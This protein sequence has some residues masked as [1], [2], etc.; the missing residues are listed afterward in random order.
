MY[1][2][3]LELHFA[4]LDHLRGDCAALQTCSLTCRIWLSHVQRSLYETIQVD[5]KNAGAFRWTMTRRPELACNIRELT[6]CNVNRIPR[7]PPGLRPT[8]IRLLRL[9]GMDMT[10][11]WITAVLSAS[12]HSVQQLSLRDFHAHDME[13]FLTFL[14]EM[15]NLKNI[16]IERGRLT[17][18]NGDVYPIGPS[19]L[20]SLSLVGGESYDS[21][22]LA[23]V[24]VF[25][26]DPGSYK[27][28]SILKI[29]LAIG[30][31][32]LFD[33]FLAVA[34]PNLRELDLGIQS[35]GTTPQ[36]FPL[37]LEYCSNLLLFALEFKLVPPFSG[38][39]HLYYVPLLLSTLAAP[40]L[41]RVKLVAKAL[42]ASRNDLGTLDWER[43]GQVLADERFAALRRVVVHVIGGYAIRESVMSFIYERLPVLQ[44]RGILGVAHEYG[45]DMKWLVR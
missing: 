10:N 34:G 40:N 8:A 44:S 38:M 3:P 4:I 11:P 31:L 26:A 18:D 32:F 6:F 14:R 25:L 35:N 9:V 37:S 43:V 19:D 7:P 23:V 1:D 5:S 15:P 30:H 36:Q 45:A 39:N 28:L 16:D 17:S 13:S 21:R 2:L 33:R 42:R 29:H 20:Q 27:N 41:R 22:S 24:G 12:K